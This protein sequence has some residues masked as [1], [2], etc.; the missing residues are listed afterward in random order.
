MRIRDLPLCPLT[1]F[2]DEEAREEVCEVMPGLYQTNWKGA[3]KVQ[4]LS[5]IYILE[6]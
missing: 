6:Y 4:Y 5:H 3:E 2:A 1:T